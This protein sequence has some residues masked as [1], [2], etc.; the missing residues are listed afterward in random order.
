[1]HLVDNKR[2]SR[3]HVSNLPIYFDHQVN[4]MLLC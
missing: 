2:D 1:M 4:V 3:Q